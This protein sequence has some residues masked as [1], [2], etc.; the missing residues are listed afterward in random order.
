MARIAVLGAG[1]AGH[2][3]ALYLGDKLGR[4]H[5]ITVIN[6]ID[7]F[8]YIPSWVWVG[9]GRMPLAK[10]QFALAP[11]YRK[12]GI[13][14]IVGK[15]TEI[16]PDERYVVVTP[17]D[18]NPADGRVDYDYLVVATGPKLDFAGTPGLGPDDGFTES[19]CTGPHA[20]HARDA[21]LAEVRRMEA[22][23]HRRFVIGTGH[24]GATCQGAAFEYISNIHKDLV[25]RGIR[26]RADLLWLSN[27]VAVGDFGVRGVHVKR[28]G[29]VLSSQ[30]FMEAAFREY[31]I[32]WQV[33]TGV[34]QVGRDV[35]AWEDYDG[36]TGE[37]P[38]D[39]AMLIPRFLGQPMAVR[40]REGNDVSADVLAPNG[41]VKVDA[42]YGLPYDELIRT[43]EA[44]PSTY[45]N[46][47]YPEIFAA[48]I[49]FA[50]P[51]PISVP[52]TT[53]SGLAI[54]AA[55][56]RTGMVSGIIGRVV[57]LNIVELVRNGTMSHGER[58]TEMY[59]ACIASMGDSLRDGSAATIMIYPVVPDF[60]RYPN[61]EG[62]DLFVT[63]MEMG[64]AGA[65]MK[66]MLHTTFIHKLKGRIGWRFI[67]E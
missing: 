64:L 45:R 1:F 41:L 47:T 65:W 4:E 27:E 33:R 57:A 9:V 12:F 67:P 59:A 34:T 39:F 35:I 58:M 5:E 63:H 55:P 37:T 50:P 54:T 11:V 21:Y 8:S 49:A 36:V 28:G 51:G 30:A 46:P 19:I 43:P 52:H 62:R 38:Y 26:D 2:T 14:L 56:P 29:E 20:E 40:D 17:D 3:A 48:G 25:R 61:D 60:R 42:V 22:G 44:W 24:P 23:E 18:G 53:P 66:R 6:R 15:A 31:G 10:T 16:H 7:R 13:R 32:R